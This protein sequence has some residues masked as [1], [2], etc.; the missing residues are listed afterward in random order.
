MV[1]QLVR[2]R[3]D[4]LAAHFQGAVPERPLTVYLAD[5]PPEV[6]HGLEVSRRAVGL[7]AGRAAETGAA[8]AIALMPARFQTDDEDYARLANAVARSGGVLVR[9]AASDRFA[10]AVAP[11]G[12]PTIDLLPILAGQPERAGLFFQRTVHLTP[13]G[14]DVVAGALFDFLESHGLLAARAR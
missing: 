1:L 11:L 12:L 3:F 4:Q 6:T 10:R 14:H 9:D 2:V 13:R 8:T 7:I 5:P